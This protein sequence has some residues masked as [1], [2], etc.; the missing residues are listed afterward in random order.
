MKKILASLIIAILLFAIIPS[1]ESVIISKP[2]IVI[3]AIQ[4]DAPGAD[5]K[6]NVNGEWVKISNTGKAPQ[7]MNGWKLTDKGGH[8]YIFGSF[9][10]NPGKFVYV[11]T[12]KGINNAQHLYM[13]RAWHIWNNK[14]DTAKLFDNKGNLISQKS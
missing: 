11:H 5:T 6:Y 7:K 9:T 13:N 1:A 4:F 3:S 10:L 2:K 8:K 12:G 14:G